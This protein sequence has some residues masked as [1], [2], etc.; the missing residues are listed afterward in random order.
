MRV[1][2]SHKC[3][4]GSFSARG[5]TWVEFVVGSR[6]APNSLVFLLA[7]KPTLQIPIR[8]GWRTRV[9]TSWGWYDF[10]SK[11]CNFALLFSSITRRNHLQM[12]DHSHWYRLNMSFFL[13]LSD[14]QA[15]ATSHRCY[16][17]YPLPWLVV[18]YVLL[19]NSSTCR[20]CQGYWSHVKISDRFQSLHSV[21][22]HY[23]NEKKSGPSLTSQ[24][25]V[26]PL[27]MTRQKRSQTEEEDKR[28]RRQTIPKRNARRD[29]PQISS[30][31]YSG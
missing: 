7:R 8:L 5:L 6:L 1:L 18:L 28:R 3:G 26:E 31:F 10:L 4:P 11:Y 20:L 30:G 23:M 2:G 21:T 25:L 16:W 15:A 27:L 12:P 29:S 24:W 19:L 13:I 22:R 9:K 17:L 14:R